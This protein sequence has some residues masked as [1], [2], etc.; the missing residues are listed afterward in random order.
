MP[1][2]MRLPLLL[3]GLRVALQKHHSWLANQLVKARGL[4]LWS[5]PYHC[6]TPIFSAKKRHRGQN[7]SS[8][9]KYFNKRVLTSLTAYGEGLLDNW[10]RLA[11]LIAC[12][13]GRERGW[14]KPN[15]SDINHK[16]TLPLLTNGSSSRITSCPSSLR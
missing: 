14:S 7:S 15:T 9:A 1:I 8:G 13:A 11:S 6:S 4:R 12:S 5:H 16:S 3:G 10:R 2:A